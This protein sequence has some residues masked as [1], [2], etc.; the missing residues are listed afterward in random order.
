MTKRICQ[1]SSCVIVGS[2]IEAWSALPPDHAPYSA[3]GGPRPMK[4][5]TT[6]SLYRYDK[7]TLYRQPRDE[8][9]IRRSPQTGPAAFAVIWP[10][11]ES[12]ETT[13]LWSQSYW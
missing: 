11:A 13:P 3:N 1:S 4:M 9:L 2:T 6:S 8:H 5:I 10:K 7:V 12:L